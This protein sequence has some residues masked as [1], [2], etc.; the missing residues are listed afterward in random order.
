MITASNS[1]PSALIDFV[2]VKIGSD[3]CSPRVAVLFLTKLMI[4]ACV[5]EFF[6]VLHLRKAL[7]LHCAPN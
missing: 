4:L 7:K 3:I 6:D 5:V 2:P 1:A